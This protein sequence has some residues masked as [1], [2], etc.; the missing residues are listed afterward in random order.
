MVIQLLLFPDCS[1]NGSHGNLPDF[2]KPYKIV[3]LPHA[4]KEISG[5]CYY[6]KDCLLGIQDESSEVY[7][8]NYQTNEIDT[9]CDHKLKGDFEDISYADGNVYALKSNGHI[10]QFLS[11]SIILEK[12]VKFKTA[13]SEINDC[14]GLAYERST[15][16]LLIACKEKPYVKELGKNGNSRSVYRF[17]LDHKQLIYKPYLSVDL[18]ILKNKCYIEK[19]KPSGIAVHPVTGNYYIISSVGKSIIV[20][21]K[22]GLVTDFARLNNVRFM[23]PEGICFD[24]SGEFLFISD[25]G[26]HGKANLLVYKI[27]GVPQNDTP[28]H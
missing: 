27:K 4:L 14:E 9:L 24:Q 20:M 5:I 23:Q 2:D 21:D 26:K 18:Q 25:E 7:I 8:I 11:D 13:L 10:D 16:S 28:L 6:D 17:D 15:N 1:K 19:F 12:P 22:N 3:E